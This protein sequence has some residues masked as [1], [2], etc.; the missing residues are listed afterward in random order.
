MS[1]SRPD[2]HANCISQEQADAFMRLFWVSFNNVGM[3]GE[4]HPATA[5]AVR[6]LEECLRG[7]F[8]LVP[9]VT[10]NAEHTEFVCE[11]WRVRSRGYGERFMARLKSALVQSITFKPEVTA[12]GLYA[13]CRALGT[14]KL[15]E[16]VEDI[17]KDLIG[18]GVVGLRFNYV[19]YQRVTADESIVHN[20]LQ[21]LAQLLPM[22][23]AGAGAAAATEEKGMIGTGHTV[24]DEPLA[25]KIR[26]VRKQIDQMPFGEGA[27]ASNE[28]VEL[29]SVLREHTQ[30]EEESR[31]KA[32]AWGEDEAAAEDELRQLANAVVVRIVREEYRKGAVSVERLA[33]II[34]RLIP[35][36]REL[37]RLLPQI[38][39]A[40][41]E[42]GM[43]LTDYLALVKEL[44]LELGG[45]DVARLLSEA[46]EEI[47][48]S[49]GELFADVKKDPRSAVRLI[50]LASEL[51]TLNPQG[52][53]EYVRMI[54]AYIENACCRMAEEA[55]VP[56]GE[57]DRHVA[58][59][60]R[61]MLEHLAGQGAREETVRDVGIFLRSRNPALEA[62]FGDT[63]ARKTG[64]FTARTVA[65]PRGMLRAKD[66]KT[67]L[68]R[69]FSRNRRHQAPLTCLAFSIDGIMTDGGC[70][71]PRPADVSSAL[72]QLHPRIVQSLRDLDLIGILSS[73]GPYLFIIALT[74]TGERGGEVVRGRLENLLN[75]ATVQFADG[76]GRIAA[77][78]SCM[79]YDPAAMKD[80]AGFLKKIKAKHAAATAG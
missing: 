5:A 28:L 71:E 46:G 78:V 55:E 45:G 64:D 63:P 1:E 79:A 33:E 66:V 47:G 16:G 65:L 34:E 27:P 76:E 39:A 37:R 77:T 23:H 60:E 72:H 40:L 13:L 11:G 51:R 22:H 62:L 12:E 58:A 15:Y 19:T 25:L 6:K 70:R 26:S 54:G 3:Y 17:V 52:P 31:R 10:V 7:L 4:K 20:D 44:A 49:A 8:A 24:P 61:D 43:P 9:M 67:D 29:V 75:S 53:E 36:R 2:L 14:P 38:K 21:R 48:L 68:Q 32:G 80:V 50:M 69:E 42:E 57:R 18:R 73:S 35:D 59:L 56:P 74:M 41:L 30:A